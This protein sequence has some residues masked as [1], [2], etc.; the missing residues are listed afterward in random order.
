MDEPIGIRAAAQLLG[1][2]RGTVYRYVRVGW[3]ANRGTPE[4]PRVVLEE[5]RAAGVGVWGKRR[6]LALG[7]DDLLA[8]SHP[9][10][11][12]SEFSAEPVLPGEPTEP[13]EP[14]AAELVGINEAGRRLG[15][16][17]SVVSRQVKSGVIP[18]RG[19]AERPLVDIEEARRGRAD[20]LDPSKRR[21]P[22]APLFGT[23]APSS[24]DPALSRADDP[25]KI[26]TETYQS[27]R[28]RQAAASAEKVEIEL[29]KMKGELVRCDEVSRLWATELDDLIS[30][31]GQFIIDLP[32]KLGL[33]RDAVDIA[34]REWH[35]FRS[36]RAEQYCEAGAAPA[37]PAE[38]DFPAR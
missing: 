9:S 30:A 13:A 28:A 27:A 37:E 10:H 24:A 33:G 7:G 18:N 12:G 5:A 11:V 38:I 29:A 19:S 17:P 26:D 16:D 25:V 22:T 21:G 23:A 35:E 31:M 34:R 32:A 36:R 14:P 15:I 1:V 8:N 20:N 6:K 4:H 2:D 3:L